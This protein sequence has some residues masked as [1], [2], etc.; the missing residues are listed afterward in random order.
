MSERSDNGKTIL[1]EFLVG[2]AD[3]LEELARR[4]R[5]LLDAL[6]D[7]R[8]LLV[9]GKTSE[10]ERAT[11]LLDRLAGEIRCLDETRRAFVDDYFIQEGWSGPRNYTTIT[12]RIREIGVTDEEAAAYDRVSRARLELIEVLAEVDAQNSLNLTLVGQG[13]SFAEVSF[14]ALLGLDRTPSTYG[15][16]EGDDDGP[17]LLDAQA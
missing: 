8:K 12:E 1:H 14:R 13:L 2:V 9:A 15:P 16:S 5:K 3:Y 7:Y 6:H 10:I 17:S 4:N 11:P